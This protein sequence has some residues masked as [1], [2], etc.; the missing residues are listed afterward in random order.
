MPRRCSG[1]KGKER[2][3]TMFIRGT[4]R[5]KEGENQITTKRMGYVGGTDGSG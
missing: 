5:E 4:K 3:T 2:W 1:K